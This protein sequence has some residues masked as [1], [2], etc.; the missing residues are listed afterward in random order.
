M[1]A[2]KPLT[3]EDNVKDALQT[4]WSLRKIDDG[5]FSSLGMLITDSVITHDTDALRA[6]H[7]GLRRLYGHHPNRAEYSGQ[8]LGMIS[9]TYWGLR[10]LDRA[11]SPEGPVNP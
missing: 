2:S 5:L 3:R 7:D 1:T 4:V 11:P 9:V 6:A 10:R 8:F